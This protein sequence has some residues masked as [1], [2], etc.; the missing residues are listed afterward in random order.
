MSLCVLVVDDDAIAR[1][2]IRRALEANGHSVILHDAAFGTT[3]LIQGEK[4]DAVVIDVNLPGLKG[5]QLIEIA[6]RRTRENPDTPAGPIFILY[7]G[8][9]AEELR[10]LADTVGAAGVLPKALSPHAL[11][12]EFERIVVSAEQARQGRAG[13]QRVG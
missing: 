11:A 13:K 12:R 3:G 9:E 8:M 4:P 6:S 10:E 7:S 2:V 5:T 1:E